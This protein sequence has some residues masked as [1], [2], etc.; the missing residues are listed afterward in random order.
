MILKKQ[1]YPWVRNKNE[2]TRVV[3]SMGLTLRNPRVAH[4][5]HKL[6]SSQAILHYQTSL[7][8]II[9]VSITRPEPLGA[10]LR[11]RA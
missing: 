3:K 8:D 10:S 11:A 1:L 2:P 5:H 7:E 6:I 4:R 9:D